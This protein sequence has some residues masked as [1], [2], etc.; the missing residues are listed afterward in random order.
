MGLRARTT[1]A[2]KAASQAGKPT[3]KDAGPEAS[4][5][6]AAKGKPRITPGGDVRLPS[7]RREGSAGALFLLASVRLLTCTINAKWES[8]NYCVLLHFY[9]QCLVVLYEVLKVQSAK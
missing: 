6:A 4:K 5:P 1:I 2:R 7:A 3:T 9:T 8:H